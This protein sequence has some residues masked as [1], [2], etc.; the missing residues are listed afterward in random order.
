MGRVKRQSQQDPQP[1]LSDDEIASG[2]GGSWLRPALGSNAPGH[3]IA[4]SGASG[5][6]GSAA[7]QSLF[8]DY[9]TR[10]LRLI[11][12]EQEELAAFVERL[13]FAR[14]RAEFDQFIAEGLARGIQAARLASGCLG[15]G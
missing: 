14:D 1:G 11:Q 5:E 4:D 2:S 8:D 9:R 15:T 7:S 6:G 12:R 13:R 10:M 3:A